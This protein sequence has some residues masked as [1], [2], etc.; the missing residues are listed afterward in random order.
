MRRTSRSLRLC[1]ATMLGAGLLFVIVSTASA[2]AK[3]TSATP[4]INSVISQAPTTIT[5]TTAEN[6]KSGAQFSNLFVYGPDGALVSQGNATVAL[7]NPLQM[8]V[9]INPEKA[10]G[11][12]IVRWIT[13]SA[14]DGDPDEGAFIFT[15]KAGASA[16]P[17][18]APTRIPTTPSNGSTS[19][20]GGT[21]IWVPIVI[22]VAALLVGL[23]AGF[24]LARTRSTPT[25]KPTTTPSVAEKE[26][27]PSQHL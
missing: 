7:N 26:K 8:S 22:G 23:L 16:T 21:P 11:V 17:T 5:V 19:N 4:G 24:S 12:Y 25:G 6:M 10:D 2:H 15:V 27:T 14:D 1:I 18:P 20:S 9:T 13:V 3:V